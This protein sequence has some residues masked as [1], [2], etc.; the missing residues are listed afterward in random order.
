MSLLG[1]DVGTTGCK[2]AA[3]SERGL[4]L[5]AR[6]ERASGGANPLGYDSFGCWCER[7]GPWIFS[8]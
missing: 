1:L 5:A 4:C 3:F 7:S 2:A 8:K 6:H